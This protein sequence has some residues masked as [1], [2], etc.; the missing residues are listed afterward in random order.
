LTERDAVR[1]NIEI[2]ARALGGL[3]RL[4]DIARRLSGSQ[5]EIL[6]Q[7]DVFFHV[8]DGRLKLRIL[9]PDWRRELYLVGQTRIHLDSVEGLGTFVELE[10]VMGPNDD[11]TQ[12]R[13]VVAGLMS[14]LGITSSDLIDAAY[15]DML[16]LT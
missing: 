2:K 15:V 4:R 1:R 12:G 7:E 6:E 13:R 8:P 16:G 11:E 10:F 3:D 14:Q 5:G 9:R